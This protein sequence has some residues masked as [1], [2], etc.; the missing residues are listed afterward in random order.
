MTPRPRR[1]NVFV[2]SGDTVFS[3]LVKAFTR[4]R[5]SHAGWFL[6]ED[7]VL[8]ASPDGGVRVVDASKFL[9]RPDRLA[10]L[11]VPLPGDV[12]ER[13]LARAQG[14]EGRGYDYLLALW[15]AWSVVL[16]RRCCGE[17]R[18]WRRAFVCSELVAQPLFEVA[19]FRFVPNSADVDSTTPGDIFGRLSHG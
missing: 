8:E 18:E 3:A 14:F 17:V 7:T 10:I 4:S 9:L 13:A 12:V 2:W 16:G 5:W 19:G 11:A 1:G 15:L 6:S